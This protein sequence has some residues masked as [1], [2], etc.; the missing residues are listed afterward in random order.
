M[1]AMFPTNVANATGGG[2]AVV[3]DANVTITDSTL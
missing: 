1:A 3:G 2:L